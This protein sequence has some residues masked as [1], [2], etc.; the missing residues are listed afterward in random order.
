MGE[1]VAFGDTAGFRDRYRLSLTQIGGTAAQPF[2][3]LR[4]FLCQT[5][6]L[7]HHLAGFHD[8]AHQ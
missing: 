3:A 1:H 7:P 2:G 8:V 5:V 4:D 6:S